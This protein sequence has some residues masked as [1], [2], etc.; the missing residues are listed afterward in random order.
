M[1]I[2]YHG[3][4]I[5]PEELLLAF[6]VD[7]QGWPV[8]RHFCVSYFRADQVELIDRIATSYFIDNGAFS[9]WREA[10]KLAAGKA[11]SRAHKLA[12]I[13][14]A[15]VFDQ[16]YW[17]AYYDFVRRW[18]L[19][20]RCSWF[21]IP[22][23]IGG[24]TQE[25]DALIRDCPADLLPFA[26][27]VWHTDE[28]IDRLKA[29]VERF[30]MVCIGATGEHR[31]IGADPWRERMDETFDAVVLTF[32]E[33]PAF[34]KLRGTQSLGPSFDYP[35][36]SVDSADIGR[37]HNRLRKRFGAEQWFWATRQKAD[38]WERL[39]AGRT[40]RVWRPKRDRDLLALGAR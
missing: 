22:D 36:A 7:D 9:A 39:A 27:P 21:I 16:V 17:D 20:G 11:S 13:D 1:I 33:V 30:P 23:V 29:L 18:T 40:E 19:G 4:P 6:M 14:G 12:L 5:T 35:W 28:P 25:Q 34:H 31:V 32:G 10:D 3:T 8:D 24:G 2:V 37:N 26:R 15:A 38:R